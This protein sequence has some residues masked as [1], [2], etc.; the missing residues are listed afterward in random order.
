MY[1][2]VELG[3]QYVLLGSGHADGDFRCS[4]CP[5][6]CWIQFMHGCFFSLLCINPV[7]GKTADCASNAEPYMCVKLL[8]EG[9]ASL[10]IV[11]GHG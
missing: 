10:L 6:M 1:R 3:G 5:E 4:S 11:Q 2:T 9:D 8:L 7:P